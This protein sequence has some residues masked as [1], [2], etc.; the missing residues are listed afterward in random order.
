[1]GDPRDAD[2]SECRMRN[3]APRP[4]RREGLLCGTGLPRRRAFFVAF[5]EAAIVS[6]WPAIVPAALAQLRGCTA[7]TPANIIATDRNSFTNNATTVPCQSLQIET[8]LLASSEKRV[9][10]F[11]APETEVRL[12]VT[13]STELRLNA[14][15]YDHAYTGST[16]V[17]SGVADVSFGLKQALIAA[18]SF[19]L[20]ALATL[21]VPSGQAGVTSGG[22]D[23]TV[24]LAYTRTMGKKWTTNGMVSVALPTQNGRRNTTTLLSN[25]F[26]CQ[27]TKPFDAYVEYAVQLPQRGS[28]AHYL[29]AGGS[30]KLTSHQQVDIHGVWGLS[31]AATDYGYG[32]GYSVR[33]DFRHARS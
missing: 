28:P 15:E 19:K 9:H 29:Q 25:F 11:D 33:F 24:Q 13:N 4:R 31:S 7:P 12:G 2:A 30:Y 23:P 17:G 3:T 26:D 6:A 5:A 22:Y 21:S 20:A 1:M 10:G 18:N 14:P 32:A 27:V 16:G 8:G